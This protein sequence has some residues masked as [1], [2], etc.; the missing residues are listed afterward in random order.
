MTSMR[1]TSV[2]K[3]A[4]KEPTPR[5]MKDGNLDVPFD[6]RRRI[7]SDI[8]RVRKARPAADDGESDNHYENE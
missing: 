5:V 1:K 6:P 4:A 8:S 2:V 3:K 7:K